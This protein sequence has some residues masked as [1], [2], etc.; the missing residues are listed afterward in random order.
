MQARAEET[1]QEKPDVEDRR[2]QTDLEQPAQAISGK[3]FVAERQQRP[4]VAPAQARSRRQ[5]LPDTE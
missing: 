5:N 3:R 2:R 1:Q 4:K